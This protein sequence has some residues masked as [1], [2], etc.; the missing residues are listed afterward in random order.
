MIAIF[1]FDTE[2]IIYQIKIHKSTGKI[3]KIDPSKNFFAET[4]Y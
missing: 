2:K 1:D 3:V 4:K